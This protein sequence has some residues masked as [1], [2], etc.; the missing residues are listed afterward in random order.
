MSDSKAV[1]KFG[2]FRPKTTVPIDQKETPTGSKEKERTGGKGHRS[3]HHRRPRSKS[4][5]RH[6]QS[7]EAEVSHVP[8]PV[9][10]K[11]PEIFFIDR[12]GDEKNLVYGSIHRY[13]V[14]EFYRV[15]AGR[16]LVRPIE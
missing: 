5:E 4:G 7:F 15:G 1:P 13:S 10:E 9:R 6:G 14:P 2:S 3:H 8:R 11:S 16:V 12:K